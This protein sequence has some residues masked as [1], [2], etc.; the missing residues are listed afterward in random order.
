MIREASRKK[1]EPYQQ[2]N[3]IRRQGLTKQ[4]TAGISMI[5]CLSILTS[6]GI[7]KYNFFILELVF[8][9]FYYSI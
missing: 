1:L 4:V 6:F 7:P 3:T 9:S 2:A 5:W 8:D